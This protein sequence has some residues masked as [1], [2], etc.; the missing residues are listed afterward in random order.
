MTYKHLLIAAL[1]L[2]CS[3]TVAAQAPSAVWQ[4][5]LGNG[6]YRNPVIN[7]DYSD[8]DAIRVGD[9][10]YMTSSSFNCFPGLQ[11]LHSRDL[12]NWSL[13]GAALPDS[14]PG[15]E[16]LTAVQHGNGVWAPSL[17]YHN[18]EYYIYYGDPDKG[19]FMTK[20]TRPEGP[21]SPL[22]LVVEGKGLIDSCPFWDEDGRA[23]LVHGVA[24]SRAGFKSVLCMAEM[25]PDG[26]RLV[27]PDR[28]IFDGH[29]AHPTVEGPK[30]Y[31]RNGYYYIFA[32]AGGVSTGWQLVLR[33][34][35]PFGPWEEK[36]VMAQGKTS[37]NGP[38][39]GAW[40]DTQTGEDWF[41]HFQD[42][43][44]YGRVVHLQPMRW[45]DDWPVIGQDKDGDGC[46]Q[47]VLTYRKPNVGSTAKATIVNP[48]ESDEFDSDRLGLQW[49]WHGVPSPLWAYPNAQKGVLRL[50][51]V[52]QFADARNLADSPNLLLQKFPAEAFTATTKLTFHPNPQLKQKGE[53]C[54][55]VVMGEDYAT[56]SLTDT[57][58]GFL[59][60]QSDC[61]KSFKGTAET[62]N[63]SLN[64]S[65][66]IAKSGQSR[67][68][69][70]STHINQSNQ[71]DA[72]EVTL[73]LRVEVGKGAVCQ[74]AYSLDGKKF[75]NFGRPFTAQ[76]GRWI[77]AKVGLFCNRPVKNNDGGWV[78]VD[79]FR[80]T[81]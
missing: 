75:T 36:V 71:S 79:W 70:Q 65:E 19:I 63:A 57:D 17:R 69:G 49:Q 61:S 10:F 77:G 34:R 72:P 39:Q 76:P 23:Y 48:A 18:G 80:I 22:T 46:G 73:Y 50:Y 28:I 30:M 52:P 38:H 58:Q 11:I 51:S 40:V 15:S 29:D 43:D 14:Y 21:W 53:R 59:L 7:A 62:S 3:L 45:V 31:K 1:T 54:G 13:I 20:A 64:L 60:T 26:T 42:V 5:D 27:G 2:A 44:A 6:T 4:P 81:K 47:P 68:G 32:P 78:D 33:S 56:L 8:P 16:W 24:G 67:Q 66:V 41:L 9:D 25:A 74:F 55:L 12:V 35:Q 37:V